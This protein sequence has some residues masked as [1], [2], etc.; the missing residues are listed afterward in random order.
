MSPFARAFMFHLRTVSGDMLDAIRDIPADD[1]NTWK[2]AAARE[3]SH[4]MNTFAAIAIHTVSAGE[5][6]VLSGAGGQTID[7]DREAEFVATGTFDDIEARFTRWLDEVER[8]VTPFTD[9][10]FDRESPSP[11]Y[12]ERGWRV[13]EVML[14]GLDHTA[15]HLGH[16]EVQ[17][18]LWEAERRG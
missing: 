8:L 13:A 18:Q 11:R 4:E 3:G 5:F 7:R 15:L 9:A 10:D 12:A 6:I 17:R 14:H 16:I 2:P 1:F